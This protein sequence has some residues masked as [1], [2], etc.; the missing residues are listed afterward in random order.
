MAKKP[1]SS[2]IVDPT[3]TLAPVDADALDLRGRTLAVVGGTNGLGRAIARL[4]AARGARVIVVGRTFRDAEVP[5]IEHVAA[6]LASMAEARRIG[7]ALPADALDLVVFTTG[8]IAAPRRETTAEGLERDMAVSFLSRLAI[9]RELGPRLRREGTPAR[10]FVMGFPGTG[11]RAELDDLDGARSYGAMRVHMN[12]VAGNEALVLDGVR[13]YPHAELFGL[14]PGLIKTDI[15]ANYLGDGSLW[16]RLVE[17]VLGWFTITPETYAR[18]ILPVLVAPELAGRS[19]AM[20]NP[21][22]RAILPSEA[23]DADHVAALIAASEAMIDGVL[24][25]AERAAAG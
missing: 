2:G 19:G 8:I 5:G 21:K 17:T 24:A 10:V 6:D 11:Q 23:L 4:A 16:H 9:L 3:L 12:T 14:N 18:R 15:R 25:P 13:R 22:P 7:R 1:G 20:F